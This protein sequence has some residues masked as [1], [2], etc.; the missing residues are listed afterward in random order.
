MAHIAVPGL[1]SFLRNVI[2]ARGLASEV[3]WPCGKQQK[4][5]PMDTGTMLAYPGHHYR[6]VKM[7]LM[8]CLKFLVLS[9]SLL[10]KHSLQ[11]VVANSQRLAFL[12]FGLDS[13]ADFVGQ[14]PFQQPT[15][16]W[17]CFR[18]DC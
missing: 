12:P 14:G 17:F 3:V 13:I 1:F 9:K 8:A 5:D 18:V 7:L 2:L 10:W 16:T 6:R 15:T 11:C 4:F